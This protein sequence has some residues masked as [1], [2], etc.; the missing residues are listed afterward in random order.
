M[1]RYCRSFQNSHRYLFPS[2]LCVMAVSSHYFYARENDLR[3]WFQWFG[4]T[5][6]PS[7][8]VCLSANTSWYIHD[9]C[10]WQLLTCICHSMK[11]IISARGGHVPFRSRGST[12]CGLLGQAAGTGLEK[13][14]VL[15]WVP[16][17]CVVI[18]FGFG[19]LTVHWLG[20]V[21]ACLL[22]AELLNQYS[23]ARN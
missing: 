17:C 21:Q 11:T 14:W 3:C 13:G 8:E 20:E 16:S 1:L 5:F 23:A 2:V 9:R 15:G 19:L 12:E 18:K 4:D 7:S 22:A 10:C 6:S